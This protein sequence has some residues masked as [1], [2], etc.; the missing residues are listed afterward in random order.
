MKYLQRLLIMLLVSCCAISTTAAAAGNPVNS[1][2]TPAENDVS[3]EYLGMIFGNISPG[4][5]KAGIHGNSQLLGQLF[6]VFNQ[7]ALIVGIILVIYTVCVGT[8]NTATSGKILGE[9]WSGAWLPMRSAAGIAL[10]IPTKSGYCV[11][12]IIVMWLV[13][14]GVG[15]AGT[16][17]STAIDYLDAGHYMYSAQAD[18]SGNAQRTDM[19]YQN[20][21][22]SVDTANALFSAALCNKYH[23]SNP[24]NANELYG[25]GITS[26]SKTTKLNYGYLEGDNGYGHEC[27]TVALADNKQVEPVLR[28]ASNWQYLV[29]VYWQKKDLSGYKTDVRLGI[30]ALNDDLQKAAD[31]DPAGGVSEFKDT[32]WL[33]AGN[34]YRDLS[35][36]DPQGGGVKVVYKQQ[37]PLFVS[38]EL[39]ECRGDQNCVQLISGGNVAFN[40]EAIAGILENYATNS[41]GNIHVNLELPEVS[42]WWYTLG[43]GNA[44]RELTYPILTAIGGNFNS[45]GD[46]FHN[47]VVMGANMMNA[48]ALIVTTTLLVGNMAYG[49]VAN[50][51]RAENPTGPAAHTVQSV[52]STLVLGVAGFLYAQG[53]MLAIYLPLIPFVLFLVGGIGWFISVLEAM[54]AAPLVAIGLVWP[55]AQNEV[56]GRAEPA[57]MLILNLFLRPSLMIIGL[58][59]G[60]MMCW[61]GFKLTNLGFM[62][63]IAHGSI[64]FEYLFGWFVLGFIYA[65]LLITIAKKCFS[66]IHQVPDKVLMWIGDHSQHQGGAEEFLGAVQGGTEKGGGAVSGIA[67]GAGQYVGYGGRDLINSQKQWGRVKRLKDR[68]GKTEAKV[69]AED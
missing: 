8:I 66:L 47:A 42:G 2:L 30:E 21:K 37:D 23:N 50:V 60:I 25:I 34:Y 24:H 28:A 46:P 22:A 54:V 3:L 41:A 29:E 49:M 64:M 38:G 62:T 36:F 40:N 44:F 33:L 1:M 58:L 68:L 59:A 32:G 52:I 9:R 17:W 55:D 27:G 61:V 4:L 7:L 16:L 6:E 35:R 69:D 15:A 5:M 13:Y 45:T 20:M 63:M 12:Q 18:T 19:P 56:L 48:A 10:L 57:I 65:M 11:V 26:D 39:P 43:I 67:S 14:W 31:P 53:V 51:C